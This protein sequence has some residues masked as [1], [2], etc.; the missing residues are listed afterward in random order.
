MNIFYIAISNLKRRKMKMLFLMMGLIVGM[1]TLVATKNIIHAMNL[2]LGNR[3]DEL[4]ANAVIVPRTEGIGTHLGS[5]F[6]TNL[7]FDIQKLTLDDVPKIYASSVAEYINIVSP[8]LVGAVTV[9]DK[10]SLIVF[11][12]SISLRG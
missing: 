1:A 2:D 3:I 5:T 9:G 4:G 11:R 8:K 12:P 7:D 6:N 10:K